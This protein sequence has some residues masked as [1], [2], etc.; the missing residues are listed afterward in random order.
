MLFVIVFYHECAARYQ[1]LTGGIHSTH[2]YCKGYRDC[3]V[4]LDLGLVQQPYDDKLKLRH[5]MSYFA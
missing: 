5:L 1:P 4:K 3:K 2:I